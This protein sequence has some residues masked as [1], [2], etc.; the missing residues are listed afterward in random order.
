MDMH[1]KIHPNSSYLNMTNN[2]TWFKKHNVFLNKPEDGKYNNYP[3]I[4]TMLLLTMQI[5]I[6][7]NYGSI[8]MQIITIQFKRIL[9]RTK[10][11]RICFA[12]SVNNITRYNGLKTISRTYHP[13]TTR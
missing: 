5:S 13:V 1:S 2:K 12:F 9:M 11:R 4:L 7:E 10:S 3:S 8:A 6:K